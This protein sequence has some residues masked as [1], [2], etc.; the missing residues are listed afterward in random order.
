[1]IILT[2]ITQFLTAGRSSPCKT[3]AAQIEGQTGLF[4][5]RTM[6]AAAESN[7]PRS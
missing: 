4:L 3:M 7:P 1:V 6:P 2:T 5:D